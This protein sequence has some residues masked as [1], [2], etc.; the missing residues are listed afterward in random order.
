MQFRTCENFQ[1][2]TDFYLVESPKISTNTKATPQFLEFA[3]VA[4]QPSL[5]LRFCL[6][7][8]LGGNSIKIAESS[9]DSA[10]QIKSLDSATIHTHKNATPNP[11][12]IDYIIFLDSDDFWEANLLQTCVDSA[13]SQNLSVV[14][15]NYQAFYDSTEWGGG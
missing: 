15:F 10:N 8:N 2:S 3:S 4:K 1:A 6:S 9:L 13:K 14:W 7:Q 5:P 12:K 11:P